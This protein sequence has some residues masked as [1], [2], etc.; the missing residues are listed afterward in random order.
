MRPILRMQFSIQNISHIFVFNNI[1]HILHIKMI[2]FD[3]SF[4]LQ[5][6]GDHLGFCIFIIKYL[7]DI[8]VQVKQNRERCKT[9]GSHCW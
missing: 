3:I 6:N 2:F 7:R 4:L 5:P 9:W 1:L 8:F